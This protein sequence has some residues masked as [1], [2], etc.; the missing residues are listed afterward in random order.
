VTVQAILAANPDITDPTQIQAG[1]TI[2]V[3]PPGW[4]P[5]PSPSG[6]GA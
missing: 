5:S 3:P 1:Q 2:L 6:S 4:A